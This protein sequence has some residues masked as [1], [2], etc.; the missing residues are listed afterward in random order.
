[1]IARGMSRE[2]IEDSR[3][4]VLKNQS[5]KLDNEGK[6]IKWSPK[7]VKI[8]LGESGDEITLGEYYKNRY[9]IS[10]VRFPRSETCT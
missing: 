9:G 6:Q 3:R 2:K 5:L 1:M 8:K 10:L 7:D 4:T